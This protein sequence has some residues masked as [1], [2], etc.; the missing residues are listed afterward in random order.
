MG[1]VKNLAM[2]T[3][4]SIASSALHIR[5]LLT[6]LGIRMFAVAGERICIL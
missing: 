3:T 6:D 1:L 2:T 5:Q 4:I